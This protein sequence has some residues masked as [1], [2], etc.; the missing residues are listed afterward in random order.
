MWGIAAMVVMLMVTGM[1]TMSYE[2]NTSASVQSS[3]NMLAAS[4]ATYRTA[5]VSYFSENPNQYQSVDL[6]TLKSAGVLPAWSTLYTQ[7]AASKWANYRD[8]SSGI[9]YVYSASALNTNIT[10]EVAA[11]S[12]NSI[13]A[14]V[15]RAG[16]TTLFSPAFG[17]TGIALPSAGAAIPDG[18]PI[19][20]AFRH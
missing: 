12:Q 9:I 7:P 15:Y 5:V 11:L 3:A 1:Y 18:S 8:P 17:D 19:W 16:D 13:L 20:I 4:M 10:A 6:D 2:N 14:G